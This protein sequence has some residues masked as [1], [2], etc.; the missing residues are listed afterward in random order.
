MMQTS[1]RDLFGLHIVL[2]ESTCW[3]RRGF[4]LDRQSFHLGYMEEGAN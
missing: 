2:H 1:R 3:H 4:R